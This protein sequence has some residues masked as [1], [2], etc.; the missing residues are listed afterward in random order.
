MIEK[1]TESTDT[2]ET[3]K[4]STLSELKSIFLVVL[5]AL[6]IRIFVVELFFVPTGSMKS[7]ILEGDYVFSTKYSY[8]YSNYS[9]PFA[10][11]IIKDRLF[12]EMPKRGDIVITKAA[13]DMSTRFIKR[14]IG[15]PGDKIQIIND[16]IHINDTPI[17]RQELGAVKFENGVTY[18]KFRETMPNGITYNSY[19]LQHLPCMGEEDYS[20]FGPY[21]VPEGHFF[22][23]GDNRD[24]SGDSRA[25]IG[26]VPFNY[27]IAKAH[28]VLLSTK[29][30]LWDSKL[31]FVDQ[32]LRVG[33]WFKGIR[34]SRTFHS[35][36][37][38][39][40]EES[41]ETKQQNE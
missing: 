21:Y 17:V 33:T 13:C 26:F 23:M 14:V 41:T 22:M 40:R 24:E 25:Q 39:T 19:K 6:L 37:D 36:N 16:V 8:G 9:I 18:I 10:P 28:F 34:F 3:S 38:N 29:D 31:G 35:L 20:N 2:T 32:I 30:F 7:T 27:L 11:N 5:I 1:H 4:P 12:P 15:L